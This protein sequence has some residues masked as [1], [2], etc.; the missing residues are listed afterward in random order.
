L[1]AG[2]IVDIIADD[3]QKVPEKT[4]R[5]R[6]HSAATIPFTAAWQDPKMPYQVRLANL[7]TPWFKQC[8]FLGLPRRRSRL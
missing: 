6:F 8:S 3:W 5:V 4:F 1:A 7:R 2:E